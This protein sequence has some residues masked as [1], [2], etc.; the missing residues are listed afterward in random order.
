[1]DGW[2]LGVLRK[3]VK[4]RRLRL[5][6]FVP[7][8]TKTT[9]EWPVDDLKLQILKKIIF[10]KKIYRKT[11]YMSKNSKRFLLPLYTYKIVEVFLLNL[12]KGRYSNYKLF[13]WPTNTAIEL[14]NAMN[15]HLPGF[16][17]ALKNGVPSVFDCSWWGRIGILCHMYGNVQL[18]QPYYV[19]RFWLLVG[20]FHS[21]VVSKSVRYGFETRK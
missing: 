18:F 6:W 21:R 19:P 13:T 14:A 10:E 4:S 17:R 15:E 9:V 11:S 20:N 16:P 8:W 1:M 5:H 2:I 3:Y 7:K 12:T